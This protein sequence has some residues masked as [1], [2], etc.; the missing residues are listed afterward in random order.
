M[1][2][3][4][5]LGVPTD[6]TSED[7]ESAFRR[8][9]NARNTVGETDPANSTVRAKDVANAYRVLRDPE[10]RREYERLLERQELPPK[11]DVISEEEFQAW[12]QSGRP[13]EQRIADKLTVEQNRRA[14]ERA[15]ELATRNFWEAVRTMASLVLAGVALVLLLWG[16]IRLVRWFWEHPLW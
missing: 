16:V 2:L 5:T 3:Y 8:F 4:E 7:I 15:K 10:R 6:A 11:G 9:A 12:L 14:T 1:S 13:I